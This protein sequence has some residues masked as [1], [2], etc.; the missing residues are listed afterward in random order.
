MVQ[1]NTVCFMAIGYICCNKYR[2]FFT[3]LGGEF[4]GHCGPKII[5]HYIKNVKQKLDVCPNSGENCMLKNVMQVGAIGL[6]F[7]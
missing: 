5:A 3:S 7:D 4:C 1:Q 2:S 6:Y